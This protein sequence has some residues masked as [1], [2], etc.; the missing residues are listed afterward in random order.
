MSE[1]NVAD[2]AAMGG[3]EQQP[4]EK[5][6]VV[7]RD[8]LVELGAETAQVARMERVFYSGAHAVVVTLIGVMEEGS[9]A[10]LG[11]AIGAL[12]N[13]LQVKRA[14]YAAEAAR[15]G[16]MQDLAAKRAEAAKRFR[17]RGQRHAEAQEIR[18]QDAERRRKEGEQEPPE[19]GTPNENGT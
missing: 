11:R 7:M 18:E 9:A 14:E 8:K 16:K 5:L 17:E 3:E 10:D 6:W 19:G 13:E 4:V 15:L 12:F 1:R 2:E